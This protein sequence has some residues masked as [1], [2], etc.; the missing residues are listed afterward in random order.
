MSEVKEFSVDDCCEDIE[1]IT[2]LIQGFPDQHRPY[3]QL[4]SV[5]KRALRHRTSSTELDIL[6]LTVRRQLKL[7]DKYLLSTDFHFRLKD[8]SHRHYGITLLD[9]AGEGKQTFTSSIL[10]A[11]KKVAIGFIIKGGYDAPEGSI[12]H[13]KLFSENLFY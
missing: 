3:L 10:T 1:R 11:N 9:D 7:N 13:Q 4:V 8:P 5:V 12:V 6:G 2:N